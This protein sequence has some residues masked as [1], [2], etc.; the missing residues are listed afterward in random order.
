MTI[1]IVD[2]QPNLAGATAMAVR[3]LGC[4]TH[5]AHSIAAANQCLSREKIDAVF[6]DV[7][8]AGESGLEFLSDLV[9]RPSRLPVVIFTAQTEEEV[10]AEALE[11]GAL[12]CLMK[13]YSL[14]DLRH[15]ISRVRAFLAGTA[16][17]PTSGMG[18][19]P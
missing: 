18:E 11:R 4:P 10:V 13:P 15:K 17:T 2:D 9:A 5:V 19:P 8:L 3:V 16:T 12:D 6:L 7:N 14:D 1:L